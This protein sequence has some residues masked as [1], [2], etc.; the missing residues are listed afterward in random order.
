MRRKE[1]EMEAVLMF[2][3]GFGGIVSIYEIVKG[4]KGNKGDRIKR[5]AEKLERKFR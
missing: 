3:L 5:D 1:A 4:S 2:M